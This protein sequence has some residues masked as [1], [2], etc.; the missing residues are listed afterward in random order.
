MISSFMDI[1]IAKRAMQVSQAQIDIIG[2]NINNADDPNYSRQIGMQST[3]PTYELYEAGQWQQMGQGAVLQDISRSRDQFLDNRYRQLNSMQS[4]YQLEDTEM[5][6]IAGV[7]NEPTP[8]GF[9][10]TMTN[11]FNAWQ[12][13][14][15]HPEDSASRSVVLEQGQAL[16]QSFNTISTQLSTLKSNYQSQEIDYIKDINNV[17]TQIAQLNDVIQQNQLIGQNNNDLLDQRDALVDKLTGYGNVTVTQTPDTTHPNVVHYTVSFAGATVVADKTAT[18]IDTTVAP[19]SG[20]LK[21]LND[22]QA[23]TQNVSNNLDQ[24]A[25]TIITDINKIHKVSYGFN[26]QTNNNFFTGSSASTIAVDPA[27][28]SDT[29]KIAASASGSQ[30]DGNTALAISNLMN[31]NHYD[32]AYGSLIAQIG[33]DNNNMHQNVLTYQNLTSQT[34]QARN[35]V[36]GVNINEEMTNIVQYQQSYSAAARLL[37][38]IDQM[39]TTLLNIQ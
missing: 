9:Q 5:G 30:G 36:M 3:A 32:Q 7:F 20:S 2:H 8:N 21:A 39:Y 10:N 38:T 1:Q 12:D 14:S 28:V 29:T 33:T 23:Y 11:F 27:I 19:T 25:N 17:T 26:R 37:S 4:Q 35:S 31:Q 16:A 22:L 13:L 15:K 18:A 6:Q 34:S 24:Q